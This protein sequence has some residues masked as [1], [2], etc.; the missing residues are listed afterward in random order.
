[1]LDIFEPKPGRPY[2][3]RLKIDNTKVINISKVVELLK[4]LDPEDR[5]EIFGKFCKHCGGDDP[6]CQCWN[7]E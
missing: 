4:L 5:M 7:D 3:T 6:N 2:P 1:M